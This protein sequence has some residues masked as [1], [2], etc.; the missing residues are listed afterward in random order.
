MITKTHSS[1][2]IF[3]LVTAFLALGITACKKEE[4]DSNEF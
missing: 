4:P 1:R 3:L 2:T